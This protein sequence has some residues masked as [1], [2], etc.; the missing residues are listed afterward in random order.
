[1]PTETQY[2]PGPGPSTLYMPVLSPPTPAPSPR[3]RPSTPITSLP[4]S[5]PTLSSH[6][7]PSSPLALHPLSFTDLSPVERQAHL[8]A[9]LAVCT[10][11]ELLFVSTFVAPRLKRDFLAELPP[12]LALHVL[13]FVHE[14]RTLARVAQVSRCWRSLARDDALWRALCA[15]H[16]FHADT[17]GPDAIPA[18][19]SA[20]TSSSTNAGKGR[21][22]RGRYTST[23]MVPHPAAVR[24]VSSFSTLPPPRTPE[25]LYRQP[26][27]PDLSHRELFQHAYETLSN[28]RTAAPACART[29]C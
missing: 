2:S 26:T 3:L 7:L 18:E 27:P 14:A 5:S 22:E 15:E 17:H 10:P 12:E 16:G 20:S 13:S 29:A 19:A 8:A 11:S 1:M 6:S 23:Q 9:L 25:L 4:L 21:Q 24:R 28:W